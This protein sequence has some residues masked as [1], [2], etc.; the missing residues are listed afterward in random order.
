M[1]KTGGQCCDGTCC[2]EVV[3]LAKALAALLFVASSCAICSAKTA[4]RN[5]YYMLSPAAVRGDGSRDI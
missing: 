5:R 4:G 1:C 3:C 2:T